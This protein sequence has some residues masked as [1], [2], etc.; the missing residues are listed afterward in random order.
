MNPD[1]FVE[2]N[3]G[4]RVLRDTKLADS[5]VVGYRVSLIIPENLP[6]VLRECVFV[7]LSAK[8]SKAEKPR[9]RRKPRRIR[10]QQF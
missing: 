2:K 3:C 7:K 8:K 9:N 5:A 4:V 1:G 10:V 6:K